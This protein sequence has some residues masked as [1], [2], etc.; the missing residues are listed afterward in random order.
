MLNSSPYDIGL[1]VV[2]TTVGHELVAG[3]E[4]MQLEHLALMGMRC[5]Q[6]AFYF[7]T[8]SPPL[9]PSSWALVLVLCL[10][11]SLAVYGALAARA[12]CSYRLSIARVHDVATSKDS[13]HA[14]HRI[15]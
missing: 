6:S 4:K 14:R 3:L 12:R 1:G 5:D 8:T 13:R 9:L 15:L 2:S 11:P 10:E 7:A